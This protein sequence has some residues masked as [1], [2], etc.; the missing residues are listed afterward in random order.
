MLCVDIPTSTVAMFFSAFFCELQEMNKQAPD[1][2]V[3][4]KM[5]FKDLVPGWDSTG[6][7]QIMMFLV[8][9]DSMCMTLDCS[10]QLSH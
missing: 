4:T 1:E 10:H 5:L 9:E 6:S 7:K 8:G 2:A 3:E